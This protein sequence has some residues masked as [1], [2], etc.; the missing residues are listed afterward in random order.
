MQY[1]I[2]LKV[3]M[4]KIATKTIKIGKIRQ[5]G[6]KLGEKVLETRFRTRNPKPKMYL[7]FWHLLGTILLKFYQKKIHIFNLLE[8]GSFPFFVKFNDKKCRYLRKHPRWR[9]TAT[10]SAWKPSG[11]ISRTLLGCQKTIRTKV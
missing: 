5:K 3:I 9:V 2:I 10:Y 1:N 6:T 7:V 4:A 8:F 11:N